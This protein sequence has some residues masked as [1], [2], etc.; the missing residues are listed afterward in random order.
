MK[1]RALRLPAP[2]RWWLSAPLA[3]L[4][5]LT[6]ASTALADAGVHAS[7][8]PWVVQNYLPLLVLGLLPFLLIATTSFAKL[9]I[10]FS[11]LR[12]ALGTGQVPSGMVITVLAAI[13]TA[14][15]MT[16]VARDMATASAPYALHVDWQAPLAPE[17]RAALFDV[18]EHGTEPLRKFLARNAGRSELSFFVTLAR[19]A[20]PEA[21]RKDVSDQD[22][23]VV[24]PAFFITELKEAFEIAFLVLVPFL[25]LDLVIATILTSLGMQTLSPAAVALPFKLLLFVTIDGFR[26]LSEA[27]LAGYS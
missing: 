17:S 15:L 23:M 13:L 24:L 21:E 11:V 5:P 22:L 18:F 14:Y 12:N 2:R 16:P 19:R 7:T 20:R 26:A 6:A 10:V 9:S 8:A 27:L 1:M 3:G 25:V 4:S